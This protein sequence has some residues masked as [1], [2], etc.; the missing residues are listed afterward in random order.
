MEAEKACPDCI[1]GNYRV[2]KGDSFASLEKKWN[3]L[4]GSLSKMNKNLSNLKEGQIINTTFNQ[5]NLPN[6]IVLHSDSSLKGMDNFF[7]KGAEGVN[8]IIYVSESN[9]E[10]FVRKLSSISEGGISENTT[11]GILDAKKYFLSNISQYSNDTS[12]WFKNQTSITEPNTRAL[13]VYK[14]IGYNLNEFGNLVFGSA[15]AIKGTWALPTLITG[16]HIYSIFA[17]G[18][19]DDKNEV[20]AVERGYLYYGKINTSYIVP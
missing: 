4:K 10:N 20:R 17:N 7:R 6:D 3:M 5:Y 12:A 1:N 18:K 19:P 14:G 11:G 15:H 8:R 2:Q 16:G 9:Y 13:F